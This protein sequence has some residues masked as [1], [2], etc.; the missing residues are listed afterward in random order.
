MAAAHAALRENISAEVQRLAAIKEASKAGAKA[1]GAQGPAPCE[2][3]PQGALG[4]HEAMIMT[5]AAAQDGQ[6]LQ[7]GA[8]QECR[9][10]ADGVPQAWK[11]GPQPKVQRAAPSAVAA[12]AV[13]TKSLEKKKTKK[14]RK[15][16][17]L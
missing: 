10:P 13:K 17:T 8:L 7:Q 12:T 9:G 1:A 2:Q 15:K 3:A 14:P 5:P 4:A 16:K 11:A 6:G